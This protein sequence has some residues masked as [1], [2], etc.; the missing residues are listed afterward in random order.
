MAHWRKKYA[1]V[2]DDPGVNRKVYQYVTRGGKT[3]VRRYKKEIRDGL[4]IL[5]LVRKEIT[6][7]E[8]ASL[9]REKELEKRVILIETFKEWL[10]TESDLAVREFKKLKREREKREKK[11]ESKKGKE[12][13][14]KE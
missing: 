7:T 9:N 2:V 13:G 8:T 3:F 14:E 6:Q 5:D 12:Q 1:N 10:G 4:T 11:K